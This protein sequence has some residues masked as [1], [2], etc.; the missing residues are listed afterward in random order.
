M[1]LNGNRD[2]KLLRVE[3]SVGFLLQFPQLDSVNSCGMNLVSG[4]RTE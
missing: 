2:W 3:F 4:S 1:L